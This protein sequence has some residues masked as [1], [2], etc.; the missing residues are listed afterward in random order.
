MQDCAKTWGCPIL[1]LQSLEDGGVC[2]LSMNDVGRFAGAGAGLQAAALYELGRDD[3]GWW[4][5]GCAVS[6]GRWQCRTV[7]VRQRV[8]GFGTHQADRQLN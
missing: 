7:S 4:W 8:E 6:A 1:L 5:H 2:G 3:T